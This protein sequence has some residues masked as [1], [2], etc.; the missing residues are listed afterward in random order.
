MTPG[1]IINN[2]IALEAKRQLAYTDL[3]IAEI[4][5]KLNFEDP[6]YFSRFFRRETGMTPNVFRKHIG[7]KYHF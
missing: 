5:Y 6:S 3:T 7:E 4:C 2:E 1:K